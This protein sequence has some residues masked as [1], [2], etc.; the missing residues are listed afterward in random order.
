MNAAIPMNNLVFLETMFADA[1]PGAFTIVASFPG[2]PTRPIAAPGPG[3]PG[4]QD[5]NSR[6]VS[7][8]A[9]PT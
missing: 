9:T 4:L 2:I 1:L 8:R 5:K 6:H 7:P 3:G